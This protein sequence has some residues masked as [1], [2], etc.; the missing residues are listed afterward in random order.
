MRNR[1]WKEHPR[2]FSGWTIC[3]QCRR[4]RRQEFDSWAGK[5]LWSR[6]RQPTL[7]FLPRIPRKEEPGGLQFIGSWRVRHDWINW[8]TGM[9]YS[10]LVL[11][12]WK[13]WY[14]KGKWEWGCPRRGKLILTVNPLSFLCL[15][16]MIKQT[17]KLRFVKVCGFPWNFLISLS[18]CSHKINR[19]R[20]ILVYFFKNKTQSHE[21]TCLKNIVATERKFEPGKLIRFHLPFLITVLFNIFAHL[22]WINSLQIL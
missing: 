21:V 1:R 11:R 20:S 19:V 5:I 4:H 15:K 16:K 9:Q 22:K 18:K 7:G 13:T 2:Q 10:D 17:N 8:G 14:L 12:F 3:L 6:A